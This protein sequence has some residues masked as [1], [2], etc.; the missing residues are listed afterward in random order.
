MVYLQLYKSS[1]Y[2]FHNF[3]VVLRVLLSPFPI[4][5][6]VF[7]ISGIFRQRC[8]APPF[9]EILFL[10]DLSGHFQCPSRPA[11]LT[12]YSM[13][14]FPIKNRRN[15]YPVWSPLSNFRRLHSS[16]STAMAEMLLPVSATF[17]CAVS[18]IEAS[19]PNQAYCFGPFS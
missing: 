5:R 1:I 2:L 4:I 6:R 15:R 3:Y 11:D 9:I 8:P 13:L 10:L 16:L 7:Q 12:L 19:V 14:P 17:I 18:T